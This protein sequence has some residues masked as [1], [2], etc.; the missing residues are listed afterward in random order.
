MAVKVWQTVKT[1][2]CEHVA[3]EV[4]LEVQAIYPAEILGE[5]SPRLS[6]HRCTK[7]RDCMLMGQ[8]TCVWAGTNPDYDPFS[9][10]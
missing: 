1:Q 9:A 6:I 3:C 5:Q 8:A 10:R 7:A 4:S 2:Y